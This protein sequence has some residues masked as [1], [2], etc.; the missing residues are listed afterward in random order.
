MKKLEAGMSIMEIMVVV[1]IVLV[2]IALV[3]LPFGTFRKTQALENT[4]D[5][6]VSVLADARTKTLAAVN[7]T[8]YSVRFETNRAI[9]F[10]GSSYSSGDATNDI[11]TF[12]TPVTMSAI[13]VSGGGSTITFD[14]LTG[15]TSQYGT[16]TFTNGTDTRTIS[17]S[18]TGTVSRN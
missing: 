1:A 7:G 13:N 8:N 18:A 11:I 5:T 17:V 6:M 3:S 15:K 9:F 4:T 10:T 14:R 12:E 2:L 16:V